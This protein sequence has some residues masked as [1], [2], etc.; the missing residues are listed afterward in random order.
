MKIPRKLK[1]L[2]HEYIIKEVDNLDC[3]GYRTSNGQNMILLNKHLA[4]SE[5]EETLLHEIIH[6]INGQLSDITV[7]FLAQSLYLVFKENDML[8]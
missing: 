1:I 7:E 5:K 2:S 3:S 4:N 6:A 8:K